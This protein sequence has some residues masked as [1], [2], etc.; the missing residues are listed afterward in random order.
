[1]A[2]LAGQRIKAAD[3]VPE[4]WQSVIFEN[5]WSDLGAGWSAVSYR[6]HPKTGLVE[7]RGACSGGT[8]TNGTTIYTLPT[9][10]RPAAHEAHAIANLTSGSADPLIRILSTGEVQIHGMESSTNGAHAQTGI[11]FYVG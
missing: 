3:L 1:M 8:K 2:I 6:K 7:L 4:A 5:G 10:Y 11:F 9:G